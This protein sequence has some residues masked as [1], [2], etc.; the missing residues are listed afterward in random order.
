MILSEQ[1]KLRALPVQLVEFRDGVILK[2]GSTEF[3]VKGEGSIAAIQQVLWMTTTT[4]STSQEI[5]EKFSHPQRPIV[6]NLIDQLRTRNILVPSDDV[7]G[8]ATILESH[9]DI[10]YWNFSESHQTVS[11]KIDDQEIV[12][13]GV[14]FISRQLVASFLDSGVTK[15]KVVDFPL[16][17]NLR[18][19]DEQGELNYKHWEN[20]TVKPQDYHQWIKGHSR[21]KHSCIV[22]TSDFG[23]HE[24][25]RYWNQFCIEYNYH[26]L[27]VVL[28]NIVGYIGP[29]IVP[30]ETACFECLRA[31][32]NSNFIDPE[33]ERA[34]EEKAFEGQAVVGFHPSMASILGNIAA[35]E[36]IKFYSGSLP[37]KN[38]GALIEINLLATF[39]A[40]RKILK[41]PRC[42]VC[43]PLLTRAPLEPRKN[44]VQLPGVRSE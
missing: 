18:L 21:Q 43:S 30:Q 23:N 7:R 38:V 35:F 28:Q 32:Q 39:M 19:F 3:R 27:P 41:N 5:C 42:Q 40:V 17:R 9:Q 11:K 4:Q 16:L 2:R 1:Q 15:I 6:Q 29:F 44:V 14:N 33:I 26:Y 25:L 24:T 37:G 22:A 12:I 20:I 34:T 36:L 8:Q 10:F 13:L 31:R